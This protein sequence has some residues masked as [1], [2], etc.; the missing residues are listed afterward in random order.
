MYSHI[1]TTFSNKMFLSFQMSNTLSMV[2]I[3]HSISHWIWRC[4][5]LMLF[6][7]FFLNFYMNWFRLDFKHIFLF[8]KKSF[9]Q[10]RKKY[11]SQNS[12]T[13]CVFLVFFNEIWG[14]N[15]SIKN[16]GNKFYEWEDFQNI[17]KIRQVVMKRQK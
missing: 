2:Y 8:K 11:S 16:N 17:D 10:I 5:L 4:L 7:I 1:S 15:H 14:V 9:I 13:Y 3:T 12:I 6:S